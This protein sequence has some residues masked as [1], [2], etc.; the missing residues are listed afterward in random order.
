MTDTSRK[1]AFE[2]VLL[3]LADSDDYEVIIHAL[4]DYH[5]VMQ[6]EADDEQQ[7]ILHNGLPQSESHEKRLQ[8]LADRASR[9]RNDIERQVEANETARSSDHS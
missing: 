7:R 1:P 9:M 4:E 6:G 2:P 3:N 5:G 8:S